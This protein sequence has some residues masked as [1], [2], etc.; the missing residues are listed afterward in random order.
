MEKTTFNL[1]DAVLD[2]AVIDHQRDAY[3]LHNSGQVERAKSYRKAADA[4][5]AARQLFQDECAPKE[6]D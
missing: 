5:A 6:P 4:I 1:I 2:L 3:H